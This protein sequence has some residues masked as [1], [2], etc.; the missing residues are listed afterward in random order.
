MLRFIHTKRMKCFNCN[1]KMENNRGNKYFCS[2]KCRVYFSRKVKRLG[3]VKGVTDNV[4]NNSAKSV[5][6]GIQKGAISTPVTSKIKQ[7]KKH[8]VDE[9]IC[10]MMK[11]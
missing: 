11:H 7:C 2:D 3:Y 6:D 9:D 4:T 8:G 10:K 5:T 1:E